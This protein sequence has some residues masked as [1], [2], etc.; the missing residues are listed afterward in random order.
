MGR[1]LRLLRAHG[2]IRKVPH[3]HRYLVTQSGRA[4]LTALVAA[5]QE[6]STEKLTLALTAWK[7][8]RDMRQVPQGMDSL[9]RRRQHWDNVRA[10]GRR[11]GEPRLRLSLGY[12]LPVMA[13]YHL[14]AVAHF[15][16]DLGGV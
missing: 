1:K 9:S 12:K 13:E 5:P 16:A 4:V 10:G 6:A 15:K 11:D 2:L 14:R 8:R 7:N 3:T